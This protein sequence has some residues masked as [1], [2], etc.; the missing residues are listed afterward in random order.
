MRVKFLSFSLVSL[1]CVAAAA[2]DSKPICNEQI[3]AWLVA[4]VPS[5]TLVRMVQERG[6]A[7]VPNKLEIRQLA[8]LGADA[9]LLRTLSAEKTA[10]A[11]KD[12]AIPE[13]LLKAAGDV[14]AGQFH[15]AEL[16]FR[17]LVASDPNN[18][19]LHFALGT[20]LSSQGQWDD[21]FDEITASTRLMPDWAENHTRFAYIFYR[22]DDGPNAVA[23]A[24][25]ALSMD[26]H[27]A[28]SYHVL[29]LGLYSNGQYDAAVH[30]YQESLSRDPDNADS[31]YDMAIALQTARNLTAAQ[32]AYTKAIRL[33]P[34]FWEAHA[35][36]AMTLHEEGRLD[37]AEAE[38]RDAKQ[39]APE[40]A[41]VRN[42]LA[43]TYCDEGKYDQAITELTKLYRDHPE[44]QEGRGCMASAYMAKKDYASAVEQLKLAVQ[45]NPSG[46]EE[47]RALGQALLLD[48]RP[49]DAI[50]QLQIAVSLNPDSDVAHHYLGTALFQQQ[51]LA[52][53]EKEFRE[54]LRLNASADNHYSLAA[55]LISMDRY[56]EALSEVD[57]ASR[58]DP[59]RQ[60]YRAQREQLLKLMKSS[61]AR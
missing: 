2:A 38:Y 9:D 17:K 40:E 33:R 44:W 22:L 43:N 58:L 18:A 3:A 49:D 50:H 10:P 55:C 51:Q 21:A 12:A 47:H 46:A 24:R 28:E 37:D 6:L 59:D 29:G 39:L 4:D 56:D 5:A 53:A 20:M 45:Q 7:N 41:S 27:D 26:P 32:L 35:N 34:N 23:E 25:T 57:L 1:L 16:Q 48:D 61:S 11:H 19:A 30:A 14:H 36:L 13:P 54:A 42:N 8:S 31:Y 52:A 60:L 15:D